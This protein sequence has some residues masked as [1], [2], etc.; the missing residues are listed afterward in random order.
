LLPDGSE[1]TITTKSVNGVTETV[2]RIKN[3]DGTI[4]EI[5]EPSKK[6][7]H[8]TAPLQSLEDKVS[9]VWEDSRPELDQSMAEL[10]RA[11]TSIAK[12]YS[13]IRDGMFS[14]L[15]NTFTGAGQSYKDN[16]GKPSKET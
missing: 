3:P 9:K 4:M 5:V 8:W 14:K 10:D 7:L 6:P 16:D 2:K 11:A 12:A 13:G 1:E 15:W